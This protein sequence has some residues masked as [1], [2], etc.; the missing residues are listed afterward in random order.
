[1]SKKG[2]KTVLVI[3]AVMTTFNLLIAFDLSRTGTVL[4]TECYGA[5]HQCIPG[6][7]CDKDAN[8]YCV[9]WC[10]SI[11]GKDCVEAR[12][13]GGFCCEYYSGDCE[14]CATWTILCENNE[15]TWYFCHELSGP[16]EIW[17]PKR[18]S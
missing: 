15:T 14:C 3:A 9:A 18:S 11:F 13:N 17:T 12:N 16:C 5:E 2:A 10:Q 8:E 1:M 7:I 6:P 4:M